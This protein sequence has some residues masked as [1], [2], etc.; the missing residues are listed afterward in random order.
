MGESWLMD[1]TRGSGPEQF[2]RL[3]RRP[4]TARTP[5]PSKTNS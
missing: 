2:R 3:G 4:P 5:P 1:R